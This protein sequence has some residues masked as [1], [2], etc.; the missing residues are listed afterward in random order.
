M[1]A[2]GMIS[3]A[4]FNHENARKHMELMS[5][6][7]SLTIQEVV[8]RIVTLNVGLRDFWGSSEGWAP[9][10]A[11]RLLSR[12]RLDRQVSLSSALEIWISE[13]ANNLDEGRLILAWANL[14][15]LVEGTM[16]LFLSA[17]LDDYRRSSNF[18]SGRLR[19]KDPDGLQLEPLRKLFLEEIWDEE[20]DKWIR[21]VQ[22]RRNGEYP[23]FCVNPLSIPRSLSYPQIVSPTD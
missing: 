15:S 18:D 10:E 2:T 7:H 13:S 5:D 4:V 22:S 8:E 6:I 23:E 3:I 16:K 20:I 21:L 12:S 17:Y 9:I 19:Q 1:K 14:G 11:A